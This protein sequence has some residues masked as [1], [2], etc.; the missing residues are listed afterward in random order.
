MEFIIMLTDEKNNQLIEPSLT[1][2][3][4]LD[5]LSKSLLLTAKQ[6]IR[7]L[8]VLIIFAA[9]AAAI[10]ISWEVF[11][12]VSSPEPIENAV[13]NIYG[14][15]FAQFY[16][17]SKHYQFVIYIIY[18]PAFIIFH[19]TIKK[20]NA[21]EGMKIRSFPIFILWTILN[22]FVVA[23]GF[24]VTIIILIIP[25]TLLGSLLTML[26]SS[27]NTALLVIAIV[28]GSIIFLIFLWLFFFLYALYS[29]ATPL[30]VFSKVY[31]VRLYKYICVT[32]FSQCG[33]RS[34][35]FFGRNLRHIIFA[36]I[37]AFVVYLVIESLST[38]G[39]SIIDLL[40]PKS[41]TNSHYM[42]DAASLGLK[43]FTSSFYILFMQ[44]VP[45]VY[46]SDALNLSSY[47]LKEEI[48]N[49]AR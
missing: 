33:S 45:T 14:K 49:R 11:N 21:F 35:G 13:A 16:S 4:V 22:N 20:S 39:L 23:L 24:T 28:L 40:I 27:G 18:L 43:V 1:A 36:T 48:I 46:L 47:P 32:P 19:R 6:F 29:C 25:G 3:S 41:Y 10:H 38:I 34:S 17:Q 9:F 2:G 8:P 30:T 37:I 12:G 26:G 44:L 5:T 7:Y 42:I 31:P 15:F